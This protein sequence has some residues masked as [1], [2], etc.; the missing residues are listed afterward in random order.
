M[1]E[2]KIEQRKK[3]NCSFCADKVDYIDYKDVAKLRKYLSEAGKILPR[4]I[5]GTCAA[6]QRMLAKLQYFYCRKRKKGVRRYDEAMFVV[7]KSNGADFILPDQFPAIVRGGR[8]GYF[9]P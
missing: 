6:H 5:T 9:R 1:R 8:E 4:R 3:K 7:L 2:S